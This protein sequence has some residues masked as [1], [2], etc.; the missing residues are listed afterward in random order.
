[1]HADADTISHLENRSMVLAMAGSLFM[2]ATG[3]AAGIAAHSNAILL[4]GLF[5]LTGFLFA[6]IGRRISRNVQKRPDRARPLGYAADEALFTTFGSLFIL[7]LILFAASN[8][9]MQIAAHA[10]GAA[11]PGRINYPLAL[12]YTAVVGVTAAVLCFTHYRHWQRTARRSDILRLEYRA[13]L[14]DGMLTL[15]AGAGLLILQT[16][17]HGALAAIAPVGDALIVL[18]LCLLATGQFWHDFRRGLAELAGVSAQPATLRAVRRALRPVTLETPGHIHD[19]SVTK[20]GRTHLVCI[21]YGP[22]QALLASQVDALAQRCARLLHPVLPHA[23]VL[24]LLT[25]H[26]RTVDLSRL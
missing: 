18:V 6:W 2:A 16:F 25:E 13:T 4:D 15:A 1:M 20:L 3:V 23:E 12:G 19:L 9:V 21:Y 5:S 22:P 10:T 14:M 24:V 17:Q 8:A 11:Q 26:P 7:G